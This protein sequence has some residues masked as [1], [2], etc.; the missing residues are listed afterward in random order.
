MRNLGRY[1]PVAHSAPLLALECD[2]C[3]AQ[4]RVELFNEH[5]RHCILPS[6]YAKRAIELRTASESFLITDLNSDDDE[7]LFEE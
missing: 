7:T 6:R 4:L 5:V 2:R 1:K 3:N